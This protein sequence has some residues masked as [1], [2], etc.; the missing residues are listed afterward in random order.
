MS[1]SAIPSSMSPSPEILLVIALA[2]HAACGDRA[3]VREVRLEDPEHHRDRP[4]SPWSV[5]GRRDIY[6]SH[7]IR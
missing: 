2:A 5:E 6:A 3:C 7:R 1:S 4:A